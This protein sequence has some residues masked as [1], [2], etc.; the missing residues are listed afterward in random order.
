MR[1]KLFL[2]RGIDSM[3]KVSETHSGREEKGEG[4]ET[5]FLLVIHKWAK[6]TNLCAF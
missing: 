2:A 3:R 6:P 4:N 5:C 1:S